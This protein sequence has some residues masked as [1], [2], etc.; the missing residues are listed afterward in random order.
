MD[1]PS[2]SPFL[3][4]MLATAMSNNADDAV[5]AGNY[6][7]EDIAEVLRSNRNYGFPY[8]GR[9]AGIGMVDIHLANQRQ[10]NNIIADLR[11]P[12]S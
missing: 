11:L 9:P 8:L 1:D 4:V 6:T 3:A 10:F 12:I 7:P 5:E 2:S